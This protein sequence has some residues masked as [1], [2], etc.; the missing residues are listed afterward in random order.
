MTTLRRITLQTGEDVRLSEV[1][2]GQ[3]F[4]VCDDT[5]GDMGW[6]RASSAPYEKDGVWG[7]IAKRVED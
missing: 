7:V 4:H 3:V 2:E 6:W 1:N 5:Q